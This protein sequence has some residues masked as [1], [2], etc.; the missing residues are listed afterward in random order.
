M[1]A[2]GQEESIAVPGP[3]I[4]PSRPA[5]GRDRPRTQVEPSSLGSG[6]PPLPPAA[7]SA[8][9]GD[10]A[11]AA[12]LPELT[13][14]EWAA[15]RRL[16]DAPH[17]V[18]DR[19]PVG[20]AV[21]QTLLRRGLVHACS[22]WVWLT[23][24]GLTALDVRARQAVHVRHSTGTAVAA[25]QAARPTPPTT[26]T[27]RRAEPTRPVRRPSGGELPSGVLLRAARAGRP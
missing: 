26:D 23:I 3:V 20:R 2:T 14:A 13:D 11:A 25:D 12:P 10:A 22:E 17:V 9:S 5:P 27:D 4:P 8:D 24:A 6:R 7:A 19:W 18:V 21:A 15:L 1:D 16:A